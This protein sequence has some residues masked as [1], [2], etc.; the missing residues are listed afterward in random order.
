M[1]WDGKICLVQ[2]RHRWFVKNFVMNGLAKSEIESRP[3]KR[4]P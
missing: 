3:I 1:R 2:R 4:V